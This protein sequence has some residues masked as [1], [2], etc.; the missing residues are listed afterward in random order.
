M[1][2]NPRETGLLPLNIPGFPTYRVACLI[3]FIASFLK[4]QG[5]GVSSQCISGLLLP[6]LGFTAPGLNSFMTLVSGLTVFP[7]THSVAKELEAMAEPQPNVLNLASTIFPF[8]STWFCS[9]MMSPHA[10]APTNPVPTFLDV[11][12]R[13]PTFRGFS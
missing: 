8:S 9:F 10:G 1:F 6:L 11:L 3:T 12:S 5:L 7:F 4:P 2:K 13:D